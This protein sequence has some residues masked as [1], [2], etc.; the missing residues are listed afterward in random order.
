[1][2]M[3]AACYNL[4]RLMIPEGRNQGLLTSERAVV[5]VPEAIWAKRD[6]MAGRCGDLP[7]KLNRIRPGLTVVRLGLLKTGVIGGA[8]WQG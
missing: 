6:E 5:P 3:M 4:K 7:K 1:M 8:L 2:T